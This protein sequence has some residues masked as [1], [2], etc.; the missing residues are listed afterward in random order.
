MTGLPQGCAEGQSPFAEG[1]GVSPDSF[2]SPKIG[3]QG[4][5]NE[6]TREKAS[7]LS[8]G[9]EGIWIII[10]VRLVFI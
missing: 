2:L 3:G 5:E 1:L 7:T 8:S 4:V 9:R 10:G 6:I